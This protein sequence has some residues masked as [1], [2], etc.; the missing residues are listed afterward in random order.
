MRFRKSVITA[1]FVLFHTFK[2]IFPSILALSPL[3]YNWSM[4]SYVSSTTAEAKSTLHL[5]LPNS[6]CDRKMDFLSEYHL[7]QQW[8]ENKRGFLILGLQHLPEPGAVTPLL[9][10]DGLRTRPFE[11]SLGRV[12]GLSTCHTNWVALKED[13]QKSSVWM[14]LIPYLK[15]FV[16]KNSD[17]CCFT[18]TSQNTAIAF[19]LHR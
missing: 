13:A 10:T 19:R 5:P 14:Y 15:M 4:F 9:C 2:N 12:E 8:E 6:L 16:N 3:V 18:F 7:Q 17:H 1:Y 11:P